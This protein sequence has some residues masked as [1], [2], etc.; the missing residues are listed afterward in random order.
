MHAEHASYKRQGSNSRWELLSNY[1][2][3]G[4]AYKVYPAADKS[5]PPVLGYYFVVMQQGEYH[6]EIW[7]APA[8]PLTVRGRICFGLTVNADEF[9]E[10]PVVQEDYMAGEPDCREWRQGVLEQIHKTKLKIHL[11]QGLDRK[12]VV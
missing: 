4:S 9:G 5:E 3:L 6:L 11:N 1:G 12:S 7:S 2:K 10:I 8:N